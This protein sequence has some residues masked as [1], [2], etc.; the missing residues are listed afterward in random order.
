MERAYVPESI[1]VEPVASVTIVPVLS[2]PA[3]VVV[4]VLVPEK[5]KQ[6]VVPTVRS[7]LG[8]VTV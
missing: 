7:V 1:V 6:Y 2:F 4:S 3:V 8:K 5:L